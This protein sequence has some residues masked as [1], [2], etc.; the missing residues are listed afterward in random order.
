MVLGKVEATT[1]RLAVVGPGR[2]KRFMWSADLA[3]A[4]QAIHMCDLD[5]A[6]TKGATSLAVKDSRQL[7]GDEPVNEVWTSWSRGLVGVLGYLG[8]D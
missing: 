1:K 3:Q 8:T 2:D 7:D 4:E 5:R 6:G